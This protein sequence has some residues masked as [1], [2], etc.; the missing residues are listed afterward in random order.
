MACNNPCCPPHNFVATTDPTVDDC[1]DSVVPGYED[2]GGYCTGS[3]WYNTTTQQFY[4]G[5]NDMAC[6]TAEWLPLNPL[7]IQLTHVKARLGSYLLIPK[8]VT[9]TAAFTDEIYDTTS[10]YNTGTGVFTAPRDGFYQFF[11]SVQAGIAGGATSGWDL[12]DT[13]FGSLVINGGGSHF[14]GA[15]QF[16]H[17]TGTSQVFGNIVV[18][19][20]G[21]EE[22]TAGDT[23]EFA[24][25]H[26]NANDITFNA[27]NSRIE[28]HELP[29]YGALP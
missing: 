19:M 3:Y 18:N 12:A 28:I 29:S 21:T 5:A 1:A 13:I 8:N 11:M 27:N 9:T 15:L 17:G 26:N 22:L 7:L 23:V 20:F 6:G 14:P 16:M 2:A 25:Y 10:A 4:I 24:I